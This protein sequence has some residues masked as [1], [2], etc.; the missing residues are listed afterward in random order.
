MHMNRVSLTPKRIQVILDAV[1]VAQ[2]FQSLSAKQFLHL[3]GLFNAAAEL[4][5]V[6]L[7]PLQ[8]ALAE[9]WRQATGNLE[10]Q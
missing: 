9:H 7:R 4:G 1:L 2:K 5:Q 3:L 8:F 6:Y 10:D